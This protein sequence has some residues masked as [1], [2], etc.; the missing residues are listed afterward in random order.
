MGTI[1]FWA[2]AAGAFYLL[3]RHNAPHAIDLVPEGGR[4]EEIL[5]DE[6]PAVE[7]VEIAGDR[8]TQDGAA[9]ETVQQF[10]GTDAYDPAK[11]P[12]RKQP[13][14][15]PVDVPKVAPDEFPGSYDDLMPSDEGEPP[16]DSG[17]DDG[18][19]LD[20]DLDTEYGREKNND[21]QAM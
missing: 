17:V 11:N 10:A 16:E 14:S 1:I 21:S 6:K 3:F 20:D 19:E 15:L 7:K 9:T 12:F 5:S 18:S 2:V 13:Q 8:P 4:K